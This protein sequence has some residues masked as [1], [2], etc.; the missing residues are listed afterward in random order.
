[1]KIKEGWNEATEINAKTI[2]ENQMPKDLKIP[3]FT[4]YNM[5]MFI[6]VSSL[7]S[8]SMVIFTNVLKSGINND[9]SLLLLITTFL[10]SV[11]LFTKLYKLIEF[12]CKHMSPNK[13]FI[14]IG[15]AILKTL[16][17]LELVHDGAMLNVEEDQYK[18]HICISLK[19]ASLHE[20]NIF[21]NAIK[22]LLSPMENPKYI[23]IKRSIIGTYDY[24][25]SFACPSVLGKNAEIVKVFKE[26]LKKS[27]GNMEIKYAYSDEGRK[28][29]IKCRTL[30]FITKNDK[31]INKRQRVTKFD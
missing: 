7:L 3:A 27:I 15:K 17:D 18:I 31:K 30:S 23:I 28:L 24:K 29:F 26:N 19:N 8:S 14:S 4:F 5:L 22:E 20:Q 13:S 6:M 12:L 1:M 11:Y 21:N 9:F 16:K 10:L 25:Y 2:I